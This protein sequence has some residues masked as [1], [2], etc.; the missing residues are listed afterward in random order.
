MAILL[1]NP[2]WLIVE[3]CLSVCVCVRV[4]AR[5]FNLR[6]ETARRAFP[7]YLPKQRSP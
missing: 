7:G 4:R 3:A 6:D 5:V 2:G 1:V